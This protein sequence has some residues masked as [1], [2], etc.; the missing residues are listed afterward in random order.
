MGRLP[1]EASIAEKDAVGS[2]N[3]VLSKGMDLFIQKRATVRISM[4][5]TGGSSEM[6]VRTCRTLVL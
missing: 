4:E 3:Q 6:V 2:D 1:K 5:E